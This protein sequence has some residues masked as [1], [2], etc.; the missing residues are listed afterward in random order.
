MD[1][2]DEEDRTATGAR[3]SVSQ[4]FRVERFLKKVS[5]GLGSVVA[6]A[7]CSPSLWVATSKN[8][9]IRYDESSGKVQERRLDC[10]TVKRLFASD[11]DH[12]LVTVHD[13]KNLETLCV[14]S[15][16][17][18]TDRPSV[19][20]GLQGRY[21]TSAAA[22]GTRTVI[23]SDTGILFGAESPL[24][25]FSKLMEIPQRQKRRS[26]VSGLATVEHGGDLVL[27]ALCGTCLHCFS[28]PRPEKN[29][30]WFDDGV[31]VRPIQLPIEQDAAQLQ[32]FGELAA[33]ADRAAGENMRVAVLSTSG[34][35]CGEFPR[36]E[37]LQSGPP[38]PFTCGPDDPL[39]MCMSLMRY[40]VALLLPTKVQFVNIV[41][42]EVVLEV[43]VEG[44][45]LGLN[46]DLVEGR[47]FLLTGDD[48][49]EID[50]SDED[51]DMWRVYVAQGMYSQ[52][53]PLCR[54][55]E[56]R[57]AVY[58]RQAEQAF[59]EGR[60]VDSA[61]LFG[62]LTSPLPS[63]D[64]IAARFLGLDG[65]AGMTGEGSRS[66]GP[67]RALL[68]SKLSTL[69]SKDAVERTVVSTWLLE[70]LFDEVDDGSARV[71]CEDT[72]DPLAGPVSSFVTKYADC[73]DPRTTISLLDAYGRTHDLLAYAQA[74]GDA[75][76][77]VELL[78]SLG[79]TAQAIGVLR[80]PS[81]KLD[82]VYTY[83]TP[84]VR[85]SPAETVSLWMDILRARQH[86]PAGSGLNDS[87][88][89]SVRRVSACF[90]PLR[91]L[92]AIAPYAHAGA[93]REI[94][95]EVIRFVN[96][97]ID[98]DLL[99]R[100][101]SAKNESGS[102]RRE[103]DPETGDMNALY[104]LNM[105]L[106]SV[107]PENEDMLVEK[108]AAHRTHY[109]PL[110]AL[111]LCSERGR[112]RAV[113]ALLVELE[114]WKDAVDGTL[115]LGDWELARNIARQCRDGDL[116]R[117]LFLDII[118]RLLAADPTC[119][120]ALVRSIV[121]E[122]S[123][124][125]IS[126]VVMLAPDG[127]NIGAFGD[128]VCSGMGAEAAKRRDSALE[129]R[130]ADASLRGLAGRFPC[131]IPA[132]LTDASVCASCNR[133]V[134]SELPPASAGPSGGL[135][136]PHFTFPSGNHYHGACLCHEVAL[137]TGSSRAEAIRS[138]SRVLA[139]RAPGSHKP[140]D[141]DMKRALDAD[142]CAEDPLC[143][144]RLVGLLRKP[145]VEFA[146]DDAFLRV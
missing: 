59:S 62:K 124:I 6:L 20:K 73:L 64:E 39:P 143:G 42:N 113:T 88:A 117:R 74:R 71:G 1:T 83:A 100:R 135:L 14:R 32:V 10:V 37:Q 55:A 81:S 7:A 91:L 139:A 43:P 125:C 46:R 72:N 82:L 70:L 122:S 92:P 13:G 12:L 21:L 141:L 89:A 90:E 79:K 123:C 25:P 54:T 103:G 33:G 93:C 120:Q 34:V 75:P 66:K 45:V 8:Y 95:A 19:V 35:L 29:R 69:S 77:E 115:D 134:L 4:L 85:C 41:S 87:P 3:A 60:F 2:P 84:M 98:T 49:H 56:Q 76:A 58:V 50:Y 101:D 133:R 44:A 107:D 129:L 24:G 15:K 138:M 110:Q 99:A 136:T 65:P 36:L 31:Q 105:S 108:V 9:L 132:P 102:V 80:K 128:L 5:R 130:L 140:D 126:D 16:A 47:L 23:G 18:L 104:D 97:A 94:R 111:R 38:I 109:D 127:E 121:E 26:P 146:G 51:R 52:A 48:V 61:G 78:M 96:F 131:A 137:I 40:H 142:L 145:F 112:T 68:E 28:M 118:R 63:F 11:P 30:A 116:R 17:M 106:L 114:L 22:C 119:N 27:L 57:N 144:E 67:M 53:L 86:A